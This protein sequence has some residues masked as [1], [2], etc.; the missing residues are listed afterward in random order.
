MDVVLGLIENIYEAGARPD[1]WTV[2]L[3]NMADALGSSDAAMGC[4]SASQVP[5]L[6][7][8][9]TGPE[10]LQT[11]AQYYHARNPVHLAVMRL[12]PGQ[13]TLGSALVSAEDFHASEFFNDW[14]KPQGYLTGAALNLAAE[15]GWR[16]N[17]MLSGPNEYDAEQHQLFSALAPHLCRA[18]QLNQILHTTQAI[19]HGMMAALEHINR[20]ALVVD[21]SGVVRSANAVAD[22]ILALED[23][24]YLNDGRL[25]CSDRQDSGAL[26]RMMAACMRGGVEA[27]GSAMTVSRSEGHS[28]LSLLCVPLPHSPQW[29]GMDQRTIIIFLTDPDARLELQSERLRDRFGLTP[30][31]AALAW[32][33]TKS[34]G[35]KAAAAS[36]GVSVAT[37]RT[38]LSSIF[39]KTGVRRQAEL[40]R[41]LLEDLD[42]QG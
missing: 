11:Y 41:L 28:P 10:Y 1:H 20:G 6:I 26:Q 35:R 8:V 23:G 39:D 4:S 15:G 33:I 7:S 31:E 30:A 25:N 18:F 24:L 29:P 22:R 38:Q 32:G 40:V 12:P 3:R 17:I 34:G 36:R 42:K 5:K 21:Q 37:V 2:V 27:S 9:R 14:C 13:A 19:G 16:A